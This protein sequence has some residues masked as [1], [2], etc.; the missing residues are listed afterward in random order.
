MKNTVTY[1]YIVAKKAQKGQIEYNQAI[2]MII[3]KIERLFR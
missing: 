2:N 1:V 3:K